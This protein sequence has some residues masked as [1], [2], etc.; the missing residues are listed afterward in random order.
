MRRILVCMAVLMLVAALLPGV[1]SGPRLAGMIADYV[2]VDANLP[3]AIADSRWSWWG[4]LELKDFRTHL[5]NANHVAIERVTVQASLWDLLQGRN[6]RDVHVEGMTVEL[7]VGPPQATQPARRMPV[8]T[9]AANLMKQ[10]KPGKASP[11]NTIPINRLILSRC[12]VN[13]RDESTGRSTRIFLPAAQVN[14]DRETGAVGWRVSAKVGQEGLVAT[15]GDFILQ[16]LAVEPKEFGGWLQVAWSGLSLDVL[17]R[18]LLRKM[19]LQAL[20]GSVTG[21]IRLRW[22]RTQTPGR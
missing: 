17:P 20:G 7:S 3:V 22:T 10:R 18:D 5:G 1:T 6:L 15:E 2:S 4:G 16:K 11:A 9:R 21:Q 19:G 13:A 12:V 14:L 8:T